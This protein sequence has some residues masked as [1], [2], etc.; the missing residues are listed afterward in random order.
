MGLASV[1]MQ[2]AEQ[3]SVE[4]SLDSLY[5]H[6]RVDDLNAQAFYRQMG[7]RPAGRD[8][9]LAAVWHHAVQRVLLFRKL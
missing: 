7:Y 3:I 8:T 2:A 5:L 9:K 6:A 1:L 4:A